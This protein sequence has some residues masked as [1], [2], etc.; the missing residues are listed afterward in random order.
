MK[1]IPREMSTNRNVIIEQFH[2]GIK[3]FNILRTTHLFLH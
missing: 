1:Y 2:I 3:K